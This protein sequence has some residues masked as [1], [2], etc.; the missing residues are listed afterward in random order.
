M[1]FAN[2]VVR[3]DLAVERLGVMDGARTELALFFLLQ[4]RATFRRE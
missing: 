4:E 1:A 2:A 3:V